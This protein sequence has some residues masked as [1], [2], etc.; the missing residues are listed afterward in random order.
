[1]PAPLRTCETCK[2]YAPYKDSARLRETF[3]KCTSGKRPSYINFAETC[4]G[5]P[6]LCGPDALWWEPR[7][8]AFEVIE[9]D[10]DLNWD[11]DE[12]DP[13]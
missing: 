6:S 8:P 5:D 2:N 1:M 13:D 3:G 12:T 9:E 11:E 7:P 10:R 4:R